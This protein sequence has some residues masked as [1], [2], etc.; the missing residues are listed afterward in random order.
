MIFYYFKYFLILFNV[1]EHL[2]VPFVELVRGGLSVGQLR[3]FCLQ[4]IPCLNIPTVT[5]AQSYLL[6]EIFPATCILLS[7]F[8]CG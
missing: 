3:F 4:R 7:V 1:N 6:L 8:V 2:A 5:Q